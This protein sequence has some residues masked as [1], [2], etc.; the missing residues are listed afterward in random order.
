ML[1]KRV[2][3]NENII[4]IGIDEVGRGPMLGR[5]Y[6]AAVILPKNG[7]NY[8]CL[9]DS[10]KFTSDKKLREV[11]RYIMAN[12]INFAITFEDEKVIDKINI[13]NATYQSMHK[14]IKSLNL[15][16]NNSL[17]LVDGNDFKPYLYFDKDEEIYKEANYRCIIGGDSKSCSIAAA[18]ILAKIAR[19]DYII[20]LC[21]EFPKLDEFYDLKKNKGYG[22]K[23]HLDGI[24]AYGI[25][26]F[27]RKS[28]GICQKTDEINLD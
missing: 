27:H 26:K 2:Q 9:K 25:S 4:E 1:L 20:E 5:V 17:L 11:G 3:D 21:N 18:S 22:T 19:D 7:F 12:C 14:S 24:I 8:E 6:T 16:F 15:N 10:K 23:R 13:K 28:F